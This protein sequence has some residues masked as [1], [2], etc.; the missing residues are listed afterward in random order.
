MAVQEVNLS[1]KAKWVRTKPDKWGKYTMCFY[2][3]DAATRKAIKE[4][5]LRNH[6]NEDDDG[7]FYR[8]KTDGSP[9]RTTYEG[10]PVEYVGNGS[11]VTIT[12]AVETFESKIHGPMARSNV[13]EV[14]VD[15]LVPFVPEKPK[16]GE[17]P[18]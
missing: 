7:L 12:L 11:D 10:K 3:Q 6:I 17:V 1:G 18:A 13:V 8:F 15:K 16:S 2:P 9:F 5:G 4:L 14:V